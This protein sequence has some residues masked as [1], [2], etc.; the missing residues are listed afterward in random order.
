MEITLHTDNLPDT[1]SEIA[2]IDFFSFLSLSH[3]I[4]TA[5]KLE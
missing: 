4:D 2:Q 1:I 5:F 3:Y